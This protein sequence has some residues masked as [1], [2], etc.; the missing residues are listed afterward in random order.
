MSSWRATSRQRDGTANQQLHP[1][2]Q[3]ITDAPDRAAAQLTALLLPWYYRQPDRRNGE[4]PHL[5]PPTA[6]PLHP[7]HQLPS[8]S[9]S[10]TD[11]V[12]HLILGDLSLPLVVTAVTAVSKVEITDGAAHLVLGDFSLPLVEHGGRATEDNVPVTSRA[13]P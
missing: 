12:A 6:H 2:H 9:Y 11:G 10:V 3:T 7:H 1:P 13:T 5:Q 8:I 4:S